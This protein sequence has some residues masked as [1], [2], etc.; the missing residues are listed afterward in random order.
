[1]SERSLRQARREKLSRPVSAMNVF[2]IPGLPEVRKSASVA[3]LIVAAARRANLALETGDVLVVAQKIISK[4]EGR[5]VKLHKI[6]PSQRAVSLARKLKND[7]RFIEV[8]LREAR[9]IVRSARVL[10]F[11][12]AS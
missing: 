12:T 1:M 10:I 6:K 4:A 9:R 8:V 11:A 5:V 3:N 2:P 7:P